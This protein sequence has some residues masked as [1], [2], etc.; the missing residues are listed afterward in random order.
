[1]VILPII[2]SCILAVFSTAVMSYIAMATPI[3]PWIASTLVLIAML[4]FWLQNTIMGVP[5]A[6]NEQIALVTVSGSIGGIVATAMG[7]SFPTLFFIDP[8]TFNEWMSSPLY[9]CTVLGIFSFLAGWFGVWVANVVEHTFI[10]QEQLPFPIGQLVYK[11]ITATNQV[12]KAWELLI[13]F[14]GTAFFCIMQDGLGVIQG[15]IPKTVFLNNPET[16]SV[17]RVPF[18]LPRIPL[19]IWPLLWAIGFV[20]GHVVA[21][22]LGVGALAKIVV[23]EPLNYMVFPETKSMEFVLAFCSGM[24]VS[25][26]LQGLL[27]MPAALLTSLK[28][29]IKERESKKTVHYDKKLCNKN[30][31]TEALCIAIA[32]MFFLTYFGFSVAAQL[33]LLIFTFVCAYQMALIGGKIGLAQLGRFAT[34]VMVPAMFL[35]DL[36]YVQLVLMATFVELC[37][38]VATDVLFGRKIAH[39]GSLSHR[40]VKFYQY[41]GLAVSALCIGIVFWLLINHFGLGSQE[42]FAGRAQSRKLLIDVKAFNYYILI[43]GAAFGCVLKFFKM[44]PL[45]VLGGLLMPLNISV[46]LILGGTCTLLTKDKEEWYPFW[47]GVFASN[48]IWMLV[49]AVL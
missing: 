33:Y 9:F 48:S 36:S 12:R 47:S 31:V 39:M 17:A 22:P 32:C 8:V 4:I 27:D 46:G 21:L 25:G 40:R 13:G 49:R 45:L 41:L 26:A 28:K 3:G 18:T 1:M 44:S 23:L 24:V 20:T 30:M 11:M 2:V 37:G 38:G 34:F 42:L 19:E 6:G 16:L 29:M 7:F 5:K 43:V 15:F 10:V 14:V 35:F